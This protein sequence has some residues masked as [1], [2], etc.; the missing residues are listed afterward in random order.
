MLFSSYPGEV[1]PDAFLYP[2]EVYLDFFLYPN[3]VCSDRGH[4]HLSRRST[5]YIQTSCFHLNQGCSATPTIV[6]IFSQAT[7]WVI[8]KSMRE[9]W[10]RLCI[11]TGKFLPS[12]SAIWALV[13]LAQDSCCSQEAFSLYAY[14]CLWIKALIVAGRVFFSFF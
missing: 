5:S 9:V 11:A 8:W 4:A 3:D 2:S 1:C 6:P 7:W 10:E 13:P 12:C 14:L